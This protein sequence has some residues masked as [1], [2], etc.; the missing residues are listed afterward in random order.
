M[1]KLNRRGPAE[2]AL[3]KRPARKAPIA[4]G[5][6][7]G[8]EYSALP[9]SDRAAAVMSEALRFRPS[10]PPGQSAPSSERR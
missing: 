10:R 2:L 3:Q 6:G 7:Q 5:N 4:G 1:Q 8:G 9:P